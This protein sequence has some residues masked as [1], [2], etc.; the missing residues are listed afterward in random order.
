MQ[1][2]HYHLLANPTIMEK[3]REE[4]SKAGNPT[5]LKDLEQL[6]YLG[7]II[8]EANRLSFGL[9]GRNK[10][11]APDEVLQYGGYE[12]PPGT[13]VSMTTLCIHTAEHIFPD[14]W[15]FNPDRFLGRERMES[16]K[17]M[18]SLGRG[19][20]KCVGINVANAEMSMALA[21]VAKYNLELFE[22]D[23]EDVKFKYDYHVAHPKLDSKGVRAKVIGKA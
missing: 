19:P 22:T 14:P 7:A 15:T 8:L 3:L 18:M 4:L 17:Y 16:R 20:Y 6:S 9:T 23:E 5:S 10:R 21:A 2:A 13:G 11:V 12:L 1:I